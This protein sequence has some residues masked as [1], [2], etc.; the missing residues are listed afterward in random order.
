VILEPG[1]IFLVSLFGALD[2]K[3]E[4]AEQP[5][6]FIVPFFIR[7]GGVGGKIYRVENKT[8]FAEPRVE[9]MYPRPWILNNPK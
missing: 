8:G 3:I 9:G 1:V 5:G 4:L 6:F 2:G 7:F